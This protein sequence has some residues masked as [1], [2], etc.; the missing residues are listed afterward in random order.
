[1]TLRPA[2][3]SSVR[4][5]GSKSDLPLGPRVTL[6]VLGCGLCLGHAQDD[7]GCERIGTHVDIDE[8]MGAGMTTWDRGYVRRAM[9]GCAEST[10]GRARG[11]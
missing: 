10:L 3:R 2:W 1:M 11:G 9:V 7:G 8:V 4:D 6:T 5:T